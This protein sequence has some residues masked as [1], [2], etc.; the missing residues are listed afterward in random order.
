M[1]IKA[2]FNFLD[3][4][5][6]LT[7]RG[8]AGY[9]P[10]KRQSKARVLAIA[11]ITCVI[12]TAVP[13]RVYAENELIVDIAVT[14]DG[15]SPK[16]VQGLSVTYD[17]NIF[18]SILDLQMALKDTE[19]EF[20]SKIDSG[21][22]SLYTKK[23]VEDCLNDSLST[24]VPVDKRISKEDM[25]SLV[26]AAEELNK[27]AD[28]WT[29]E[30]RAAFAKGK[31]ATNDLTLNDEKRVYYTVIPGGTIKDAYISV[32]DACLLLDM[33]AELGDDG[34]YHIDTGKKFE[35]V[36]PIRLESAG[37]FQGVNSVLVGDATTGEIYYGYN[38][39]AVFPIAS[40]TKLM[41]YLLTMDSIRAGQFDENTTIVISKE[42][43]ELSKL[44]D[45][46]IPMKAGTKVTVNEMI[47]GSLLK[48]SNECA[49]MLAMTVSEDETSFVKLMND[50]AAALS[51]NT[52]E[53]YNCNGLPTYSETLIPGK[54]QNRMSAYDMFVMASNILN[55]YPEV[56]EVTSTK[57]C[58]LDGLG[59]EVKNTN[60]VLFNVPGVTGLKTG[61]T[62]KSGACLVS[63]LLVNDGYTDHDL[64][65]VL[66]GAE[67][68]I[69]RAR[70]SEVLLRY[71]KAVVLGEA[72]A[73]NSDTDSEQDSVVS[74]EAIV[75]LVVNSVMKNR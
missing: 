63:S 26:Q 74:A 4:L 27:S 51:M 21:S 46:V 34:V 1:M 43:E 57:E 44:D 61:T 3:K 33:A 68:N 59:V 65:V 64:V 41:T 62:N 40:T 8:K 37:Y 42:A 32:A 30:E 49:H 54:M 22:L 67:N 35:A 16:N 69:D 5:V 15:S 60:P 2:R 45:G 66:F 19:K 24:D 52:A 25:A 71:G 73:V 53:F 39:S 55:T 14:V 48:S 72:D 36:N 50:K 70:V 23:Y 17:N 6:K 75:N 58:K 10:Y 18:I 56:K 12:A 11:L 28:G 13:Q 9:Q 47:Y 31:L 38:T 7:V 29:S 20:I